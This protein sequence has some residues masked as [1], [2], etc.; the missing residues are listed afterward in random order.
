MNNVENIK[1]STK[2]LFF[3]I[4]FFEHGSAL[5]VGLGGGADRDAWIAVLLGMFSGICLFFLYDRLYKYYPEE[6]LTSY[7][8][9][10]LGPFLGRIVAVMYL[11]YFLYISARVL[12]DFGEFLIAFSYVDTPLFIISTLMMMTMVYA[13][14]KGFEVIARTGELFFALLYLLAIPGFILIIA[15]GL[16]DLSN[17]KPILENGWKPV[18]KTLVTSTIY[19]P[20]GEMVVF[21]MLLPYLKDKS[22]ST[23]AG[24]SAILLSGIN[25]TLTMVINISVLGLDL[26]ERS[27]FPF[28]GTIQRIEVA[29]FLERLDVFFMVYLI[30]G[31]FFKI[32]IFFYAVLIGTAELFKFKD[33]KKLTYPFGILLLLLSMS[34]ASSYPEHIKEGTGH[35]IIMIHLVPQMLPLLLLVIAYIQKKIRK[36][37]EHKSTRL[38]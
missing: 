4:I 5:V 22:K 35:N 17:L 1:I 26:F 14:Y 28:L 3:L 20:F 7:V 15:S 16:V 31:G 8:Q 11:V 34:I 13:V 37:K 12:R 27:Q 33:Y 32:S 23:I 24:I 38:S 19:F 10:I 36:N 9:K 25:L 2:Q 29:D 21:L 18:L 30:L 6:P